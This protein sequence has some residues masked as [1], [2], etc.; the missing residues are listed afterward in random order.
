MGF[1]L[2]REFLMYEFLATVFYMWL[3]PSLCRCEGKFVGAAAAAAK[4]SSPRTAVVLGKS[5]GLMLCVQ[6]ILLINVVVRS[7]KGRRCLIL[8]NGTAVARE[9]QRKDRKLFTGQATATLPEARNKIRKVA[10]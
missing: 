7:R 1:P 6:M 9:G 8:Q 10:R 2:Y 5:E 4:K 3:R